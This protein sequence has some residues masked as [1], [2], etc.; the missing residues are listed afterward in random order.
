MNKPKES[1]VARWQQIGGNR[2]K[3]G[4]YA[5]SVSEDPPTKY[6]A[7]AEALGYVYI[8]RDQAK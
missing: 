8:N 5:V 1:W 4:L 6:I 3:R 2:Y 7:E